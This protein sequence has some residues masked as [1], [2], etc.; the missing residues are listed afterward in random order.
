MGQPET[1]P[2]GS[3]RRD[4]HDRILPD[5]LNFNPSKPAKYPNGRVFTETSSITAS[6]S[7]KGESRPSGSK[8]HSD[9]LKEFP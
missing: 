6:P 3:D 5:M 2:R 9:T 7:S 1:Y 4:R 8:P